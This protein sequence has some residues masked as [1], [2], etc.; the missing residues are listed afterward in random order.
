MLLWAE[1][2]ASEYWELLSVAVGGNSLAQEI[3]SSGREQVVS[4]PEETD[5]ANAG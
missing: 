2:V 1:R 3:S 5:N 4:L